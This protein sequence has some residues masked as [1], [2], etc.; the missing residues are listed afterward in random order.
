MGLGCWRLK[1]RARVK[2]DW[3]GTVGGHTHDDLSGSVAC[4]VCLSFL[5]DPTPPSLLPLCFRAPQVGMKCSVMK[6]LS[7]GS[8]LYPSPTK[9]AWQLFPPPD[10]A[11]YCLCLEVNTFRVN[12]FHYRLACMCVFSRASGF[13]NE[14]MIRVWPVPRWAAKCVHAVKPSTL[15]PRLVRG[16]GNPIVSETEEEMAEFTQN[17]NNVP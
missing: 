17:A 11:L 10:R 14:T 2:D 16:D 9:L 7:N 4:F 5:S 8:S 1:P 3:E 13:V 15:T 12:I 6:G